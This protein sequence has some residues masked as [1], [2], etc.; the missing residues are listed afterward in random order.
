MSEACRMKKMAS[1]PLSSCWLGHAGTL[2]YL[3]ATTE[4]SNLRYLQALLHEHS[5]AKLETVVALHAPVCLKQLRSWDLNYSQHVE[6]MAENRL[7]SSFWNLAWFKRSLHSRPGHKKFDAYRLP[8]WARNLEL[9]C[10][11]QWASGCFWSSSSSEVKHPL[12]HPFSGI[13]IGASLS[14]IDGLHREALRSQRQLQRVFLSLSP[15][16]TPT[17]AST[18]RQSLR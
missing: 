10:S 15:M 17:P 4:A 5:S 9:P 1:Q 7:F 12:S 6:G 13:T 3:H 2:L 11:R 18:A 14:D 16:P 8:K